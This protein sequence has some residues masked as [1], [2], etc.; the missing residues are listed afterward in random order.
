MRILTTLA[1][2]PGDAA[3]PYRLAVRILA[4]RIARDG[5]DRAAID[6]VLLDIVAEPDLDE[7][8]LVYSPPF[9]E[10][11]DRVDADRFGVRIE[12]AIKNVVVSSDY[13]L[14]WVDIGFGIAADGSVET[15][16]VLRGSRSSAWAAPLVKM[17][18]GRRYI[19]SAVT[20]GDDTPGH[21]RIERYTLTADFEVPIGSLIR[22]RSNKPHFEQLDLTDGRARTPQHAS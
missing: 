15:P 7:P 12:D 16:E 3:R 9:P 19:P 11:A 10:P 22:R 6:A 13:G 1:A 21:Y 4:A 2:V 20:G 5:G 8:M 14:Q 17:I 18:A